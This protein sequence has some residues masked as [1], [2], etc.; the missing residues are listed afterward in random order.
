[1]RRILTSVILAAIAAAG[2]SVAADEEP[3]PAYDLELVYLFDS[4][5]HEI[6]F[7]IGNTG[8]RTVESLKNFLTS[9]PPGTKL[10]WAPGCI[11]IGK[12]PLLSSEYEMED[13]KA[14]CFE[15]G[16]DFVLIPSG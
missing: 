2:F 4:P 11:R 9:V 3:P 5:E 16:I 12:E 15:H 6:L 1:M 7:V 10:T 14:F 13:F 8:F